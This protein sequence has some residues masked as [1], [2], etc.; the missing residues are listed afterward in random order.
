MTPD[1]E[2]LRRFA[3]T[4]SH[5]AFAELVKRH[6]NL[7]YSTALRK[8]NGDE[9][10]AKDVAQNV[11]ADLARKAASL[12]RHKNLTGWL[13]TSAHFAAVKI[14]RGENRRRDHEEKFM[15]ESEK[16]SGTGVSPIESESETEWQKISPTLDDAMHELKET[17]RDAILFRYFENRQFAE[18]GAKLGLN[19]NAA[20]MR[21][22]RALEKLRTI[23]GKR[24]ITIA[25]AFASVI[26]ANAIQTAPANLAATLTTA[27]IAAAGTGTF[28][29]LKIM[30]VTKLKLAV[31]AII[32][33]GAATAFVVQ[34]QTQNKLRA[35]NESLT[36]QIA[37]LQTD[38]ENFSNRVAEIG[39]TKKLSDDQFNELLKLRGEV[40]V[41]QRQA[42]EEIN[43]VNQ[44]AHAAEE[45]L[46]ATLSVQAKFKAQETETISNMKQLGLAERLFAGDNN[47]VYATNLIQMT[48]ELGPLYT[49][50]ELYNI[51]FVNAGTV[52]DRYPQ[53]LMFRERLARQASDGTWHR[54]YGF[55]DGSVWVATS[56]DGNF[57]AW[58]KA[59]TVSPPPNQ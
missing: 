33:A 41:L 3:K 38:N 19:E 16:S 46:T 26:S 18:V 32:V 29:L 43:A 36:Q 24:G 15:R 45:K 30:T 5:D 2:L 44:K 59:N 42:D 53:M 1:S 35:E 50:A 56:Y 10:M 14:V 49:N 6:V 21:V 51:E 20:R 40:G 11:F 47:N 25:T 54:V 22:E 48:N 52:N 17:D 58:E 37:Q 12:S 31:S 27:S 39:D 57:D 28:T 9:H 13:Y 23:F 7:V 34:Q 55:S 4:N 8:M